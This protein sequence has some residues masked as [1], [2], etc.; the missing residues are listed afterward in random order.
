MATEQKHERESRFLLP[1]LIVVGILCFRLTAWTLF[2]GQ[3]ALILTDSYV[4]SHGAQ[5]ASVLVLVAVVSALKP[6]L[7][8][9]APAIV[10]AALLMAAS[11]AWIVFPAAVIR[12][13]VVRV[14]CMVHGAASAVIFIGW[15]A[16]TCRHRP[17]MTAVCVMIAFLLDSMIAGV[18]DSMP[19]LVPALSVITPLIAG[20]LLVLV[21]LRFQDSLPDE[22][23]AFFTKSVM[24]SLPWGL[25]AFLFLCSLM[26]TISSVLAPVETL[27]RQFSVNNF[28]T[29]IFLTALAA[30]LFLFRVKKRER[31]DGLWILFSF[32]MF[33]GLVAFSSLSL[34][35]YSL[36][37]GFMRATQDCLFMFSWI[38]VAD[39]AY[40]HRLP[41]VPFFGLCTIFVMMPEPVPA[42]ILGMVLAPVPLSAQGPLSV[43]IAL[44]MAVVLVAFTLVLLQRQARG[45][46]V[47]QWHDSHLAQRVEELTRTFGFTD[48]ESEVAELLLQ[49]YSMPQISER[50]F[51]S[52]DTV[53]THMR[54]IYQK[55]GV[56]SKVELIELSKKP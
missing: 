17:Q 53:R 22:T 16:V 8:W 42:A 48:R 35:D 25:L 49:G 55:A 14:A 51:V 28:W 5:I 52:L 46:A 36:A 3:L 47:S 45:E 12:A 44:I 10:V 7:R 40:H 43:T 29:P 37:L 31:S 19:V 56:H 34:V 27:S 32:I 13:D 26:V 4:L 33:C 38:L 21:L 2:R 18:L 9:R 54:H 6:S 11:A 23:L 20:G 39:I 15:G 30:A 1:I 41:A 50:L 24:R